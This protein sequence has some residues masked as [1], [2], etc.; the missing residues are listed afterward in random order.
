MDVN[1]QVVIKVFE[2]AGLSY[3]DLAQSLS[4]IEM[5]STPLSGDAMIELDVVDFG[6]LLIVKRIN[7]CSS[8]EELKF[9]SS[10]LAFQLPMAQASAITQYLNLPGGERYSPFQPSGAQSQWLIP[11]NTAM[12]QIQVDARWLEHVLGVQAIKDY[13]ELHKSASR[14]AYD[15]DALLAAAIA[16]EYAVNMAKQSD[17][18]ANPIS[19]SDLENLITDILLPCIMSDLEDVKASTRQ[20]ILSKALGYISDNYVNP[21]RLYELTNF[22]S[23]SARNLQMVFK[24]ELGISPTQYIHQFRLHRFRLHLVSSSSVTEAAHISGFKHL[25]RLTEQYAKVFATYPSDD[26]LVQSKFK[27]EIGLSFI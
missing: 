25:G 3:F 27:L 12:Y 19:V 8:I 22:V 13:A 18:S 21:I 5:T 26:L 4:C 2:G 9:G 24:Q 20:K 10:T 1:N 16:T 15:P 23:T 7:S 6:P 14:K 11:A 17:A